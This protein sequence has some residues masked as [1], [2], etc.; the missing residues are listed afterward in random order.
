MDTNSTD[1]Q[2]NKKNDKKQNVADNLEESEYTYACVVFVITVAHSCS[3]PDL[4]TYVVQPP[5]G[6][7]SLQ[8]APRGYRT[9]L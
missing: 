3:K 6:Y 2:R 4:F 8:E 1:L 7:R 9:W 5:S